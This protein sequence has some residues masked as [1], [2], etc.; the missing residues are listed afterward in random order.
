MIQS[1]K[2]RGLIF[3]KLEV[4]KVRTLIED[5]G[6]LFYPQLGPPPLRPRCIQS[7]RIALLA[8]S[9]SGLTVYLLLRLD[10]R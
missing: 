3:D 6:E 10:T 5:S 7:Y 9:A 4:R 8:S 1:K 2:E